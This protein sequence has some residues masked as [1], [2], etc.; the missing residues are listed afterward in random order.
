M[1]KKFVALLMVAG[2]SCTPLTAAAEEVTPESI[3]NAAGEY[4]DSLSS[5]SMKMAL[6]F[7]GAMDIASEDTPA[8]TLALSMDGDFDVK[9]IAEPIQMSMTGT[10]DVAMMGQKQTMGMEMYMI[11]SDDSSTVDTYIKMDDGSGTDMEWQH[12]Q[13][14]MEQFLSTMGVSSIEELNQL[15]GEDLLPEGITLEWS[16]DDQTDAYLLS[17]ELPFSDL[18]PLVEESMSASGSEPDDESIQMIE[19]LLGGFKLNFSY[20]IAKEDYA[21]Q[22]FHVDFNDSDLTSLN[23]LVSYYMLYS[24][25]DSDTAGMTITLKLNDFS[26]D[27]TYD[28]TPVDKIEVPADALATEAEKID[29]ADTL[30]ELQ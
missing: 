26:M 5:M 11:A 7:D 23:E 19:S 4:S 10:F 1:K 29:V 8:S 18:L 17:S 27:G 20:T 16:L 2:L 30:E 3:M 13:V 15:S 14:D 6:N 12:Q 28:Y 25:E 24:Q 22:A 9:Y 21:P